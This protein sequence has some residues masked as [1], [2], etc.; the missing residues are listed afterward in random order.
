MKAI[1]Y[2]CR[3][4]T[5]VSLKSSRFGGNTSCVTVESGGEVLVFDAGS[6]LTKIPVAT[7]DVNILISHLHLDHIIGLGTFN[8]AWGKDKNATIYTCNRGEK[9]LREQVLG[10]FSPP[11]W[12][13][14]MAEKSTA[15]V[16]E[17]TPDIPFTVG[18]FTI[19]PF[20]SSHSD[21]TL[22]FH[23]T[24]GEKSVV[25]LLDYETEKT[26]DCEYKNLI[27]YCTNADL[28]I[29]DAT[30]S[31]EDYAKHIGWGHSTVAQGVKFASEVKCKAMVFSHFAQTYE[32]NEIE[33]WRRHFA[34][35][36]G[37]D[38]LLAHDG[39]EIII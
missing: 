25:H 15:R 17:I 20:L 23:A 28:V 31:E 16:T 7:G 10:V 29:F 14:S 33:S 13:V 34:E 1:I 5:P 32:D 21:K 38:F 26:S 35:D 18:R 39:L 2:G 24:D 8:P 9:P 37:I 4:S 19:T 3:G 36:T 11:L 27:K 12:P 30:Y 22:A 6:G